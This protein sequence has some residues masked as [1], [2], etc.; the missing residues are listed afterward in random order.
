MLRCCPCRA[1][2]F[3]CAHS[4]G[5]RCALR[6]TSCRARCSLRCASCRARCCLGCASCRTCCLRCISCRACRSLRCAS[7]RARCS[8]GCA[9]CRTASLYR[10]LSSRSR[11]IS[12]RARS[13]WSL[14]AHTRAVALNPAAVFRILR[15][16]NKGKIFLFRRCLFFRFL[17]PC[18]RRLF[19]RLCRRDFCLFRTLFSRFFLDFFHY[20]FLQ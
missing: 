17:C 19:L 10:S 13:A 6:C 11:C 20:I 1:G 18:L 15:T 14:G 9:A 8:L 16:D 2:S 7:C 3:L 4:C 12:C 5:T